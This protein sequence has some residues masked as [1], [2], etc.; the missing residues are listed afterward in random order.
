MAMPYGMACPDASVVVAPPARATLITDPVRSVQ[1]TLVAL[2]AMPQGCPPEASVTSWH[3][4]AE[5]VPP[6]QA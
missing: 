2:T 5:Q 4:P 3:T 1:Y 6:Q